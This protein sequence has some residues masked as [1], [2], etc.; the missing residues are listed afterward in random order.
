MNRLRLIPVVIFAA[1]ALLVIKAMA[2]MA[3][4]RMAKPLTV[5]SAPA[6]RAESLPEVDVEFTGAAPAATPAPPKP[7]SPPAPVRTPE[8]PHGI[9]VGV[10][11]EQSPAQ[12]ALLERLQQRRQELDARQRDLEL[13]ETLIRE[14]EQRLEARLNELRAIENPGGETV[15]DA[16]KIKNLVIIYEGMKPKDAARIF[17]KLDMKVLVDVARAMKPQK[18]AEILATIP[19]EAAQRL[20]V[21][22]AR[23]GGLDRA[24]PPGDLQRVNTP[25]APQ[26]QAAPQVR[27]APPVR[28]A[29]PAR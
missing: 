29:P 10:P 24:M 22:L 12:K 6:P 25:P 16:Q 26:R 9:N 21:E 11:G 7:E 17:D 1:A 23:G 13:R 8:A 4:E 28:P 20:T 3:P 2:V 27:A 19:A 14:A 15:T 5:V 18:L